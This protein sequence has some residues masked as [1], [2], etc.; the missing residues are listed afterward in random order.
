MATGDRPGAIAALR[1]ATG[2]D[3]NF[4]DAH[5]LLGITLWQSGR[6]GEALTELRTGQKLGSKAESA[7]FVRQVERMVSLS[8]RLPAVL[9]GTDKPVD[10][11]EGLAFALMAYH[12]RRYDSSAKLFAEALKVNPKLADD[13]DAEHRYNAAC[14]ATL[15]GCGQGKDDAPLDEAAREKRRE[16][17]RA[18]LQAELAAWAKLVEAGPIKG[19]PVIQQKLRHWQRDPDLAGV[20]DAEALK[21]LPEEERKAWKALWDEVANLLEKVQEPR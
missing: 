21:A 8:K 2:L 18:W 4:A 5:T 13:R 10:A 6:Y 14:S 12:S 3:P 16:Q 7:E 9:A 11:A 20:R 15:A 1:K 19:R 17:A